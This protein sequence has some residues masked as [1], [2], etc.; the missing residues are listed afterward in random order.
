MPGVISPARLANRVGFDWIFKATAVLRG[1]YGKISTEVACTSSRGDVHCHGPLSLL[2]VGSLMTRFTG[3][4][5]RNCAT[6]T[7]LASCVSMLM[8]SSAVFAQG[9]PV[10]NEP[11]VEVTTPAPAPGQ[12]QGFVFLGP[13]YKSVMLRAEF[14]VQNMKI[15]HRGRP[16]IFWGARIATLEQGSPLHALGL[17]SQDVITR[18]DGISIATG[19]TR[20]PPDNVWQPVQ[21]EKHF[22]PTKVRFIKTGTQL[23][24]EKVVDLGPHR[25]RRPTRPPTPVGPPPI[26]P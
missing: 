1:F 11:A 14:N 25:T 21:M 6:R 18:L 3:V 22:G 8:T 12:P 13:G 24:Q 7:V 4:I 10:P 5:F 23:V 19:M 16:T 9:I 15:T 17:Q 2:I 20:T 26:A